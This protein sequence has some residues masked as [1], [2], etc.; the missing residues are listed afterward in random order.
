ML[1]S[2][3]N[4]RVNTFVVNTWFPLDSEPAV[5][6]MAEDRRA[7]YD[8]FNHKGARSAKWFEVVKKFL[9]LAFAGDCREVK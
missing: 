6:K 1:C 7:M 8:G 9:K 3:D 5:L 2:I 4:G